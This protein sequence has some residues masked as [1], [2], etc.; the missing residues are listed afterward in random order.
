MLIIEIK[1]YICL[2]EKLIFFWNVF[3]FFPIDTG[4]VLFTF[5]KRVYCIQSILSYPKT[6]AVQVPRDIFLLRVCFVLVRLFR[7]AWGTVLVFFLVLFSV[8]ENSQ[9]LFLCEPWFRPKCILNSK[10]VFWRWWT[11]LFVWYLFLLRKR[12][13]IVCVL[14]FAFGQDLVLKYTFDTR[15]RYIGATRMLLQILNSSLWLQSIITIIRTITIQ[16]EQDIQKI[17]MRK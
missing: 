4:V 1:L 8:R 10:W 15:S 5:L 17:K 12:S 7:S 11:F 9:I 6:F 3:N 2:N 16:H 14:R 13:R